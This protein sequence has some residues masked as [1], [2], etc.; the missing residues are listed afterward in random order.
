MACEQSI[1]LIETIE[2]AELKAPILELVSIELSHVLMV[3]DAL[4]D[5]LWDLNMSVW[6][7][8]S[9]HG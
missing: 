8:A 6:T 5:W 9:F 4:V 2:W 1:V 3:A 7:Q